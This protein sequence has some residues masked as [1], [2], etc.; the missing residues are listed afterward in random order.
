MTD[1]ALSKAANRRA[2]NAGADCAVFGSAWRGLAIGARKIFAGD[3]VERCGPL[4]GG[5]AEL[6]RRR[7]VV[8]EKEQQL[9]LG[10]GG[11]AGGRALG[12][13][14]E[15]QIVDDANVLG[16]DGAC[17]EVL[18]KREIAAAASP[19]CAPPSRAS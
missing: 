11:E 1:G 5:D 7:L 6:G 16:L 10:L 12:A 18:L 15:E 4:G 3:D 19:T 2:R 9:G 17:V 14:G 13:E 8:G